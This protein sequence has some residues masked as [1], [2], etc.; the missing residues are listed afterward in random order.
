MAQTTADARQ[1]ILLLHG[2]RTHAWWQ[3]QV[4]PLLEAATGATVIPLKYGRF[5]LLRF[6][7]PFGMCRRGPI[8]RLH[9]EIRDTLAGYKDHEVS[10][11]AHSYGTYAISR[12]LLEYGDIRM[13]RLILCGSVIPNDFPWSRM[14]SQFA[15]QPMR[16]GVVNDCGTKDIWPV[17]AKSTSWGFGSSGTYGFGSAQ[18]TDRFHA[19]PHSGYFDTKF[20]KKFWSPFMADGTIVPSAVERA[21]TGTPGWFALLELPYQWLSAALAVVLIGLGSWSFALSWTCRNV[22]AVGGVAA[23]KNIDVQGITIRRTGTPNS[24]GNDNSDGVK[25]ESGVA[26]G[27]NIKAGDIKIDNGP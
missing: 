4:K 26:A 1:V 21:G 6:W 15:T 23:C 20:V 16:D 13:G 17:L 19:L 14:A 3:G 27:G 10:I 18:V 12:I 25:V 5:D 11:I 8:D 24:P 2:I 9:H 7:C 22:E